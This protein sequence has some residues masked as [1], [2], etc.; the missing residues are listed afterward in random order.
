MLEGSRVPRERS[1]CGHKVSGLLAGARRG[2]P[3]RSWSPLPRVTSCAH[4]SIWAAM[5]ELGCENAP[6]TCLR[7]GARWGRGR[8]E[9]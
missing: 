3:S 9:G 4:A 5:P 1:T 8:A 7:F 6:S 2:A